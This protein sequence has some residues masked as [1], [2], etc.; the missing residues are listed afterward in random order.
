MADLGSEQQTGQK[1]PP[2]IAPG[3]ILIR[4]EGQHRGRFTP[5]P[6]IRILMNKGQAPLRDFSGPSLSTHHNE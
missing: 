3:S 6:L 4:G 1:T 5:L 2:T